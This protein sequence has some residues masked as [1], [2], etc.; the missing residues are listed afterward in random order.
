MLAVRLTALV[1]QSSIGSMSDRYPAGF[2]PINS[3]TPAKW[4][5]APGQPTV[6][7]FNGLVYVKTG[8]HTGGTGKPNEEEVGGIR[9][10]QLYTP[11]NNLSKGF[12][13]Y[14]QH[15]HSCIPETGSP[16]VYDE[17]IYSGTSNYFQEASFI[18][19][20]SQNKWPVST[21]ATSLR[22]PVP[23]PAG[24]ILQGTS[25]IF[26]RW[27]L[28]YIPPPYITFIDGFNGYASAPPG[29]PPI[30][31]PTLPPV[32][33][34][35]VKYIQAPE[36]IFVGKTYTGYV[37]RFDATG[38]WVSNGSGG[39]DYITTTPTIT[40]V[41]ITYTVAQQNFI[42]YVEGT[43]P[44]PLPTETF[45]AYGAEDAWV[46]WGDVILTSVTP[47]AND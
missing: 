7:Q 19:S 25:G 43:M 23:I 6:V 21:A 24:E 2:Y 36:P 4:T 45:T 15:L 30:T 28:N 26:T 38:S 17:D 34:V 9:T 44:Y 8:R 35:V 3:T 42:D 32:E 5:D 46:G 41:P 33:L 22:I 11:A 31:P 10:W 13:Y 40:Q 39:Y 37:Q 18:G 27:H 14:W 1:G 16:I 29:S 20:A 12:R 47:S